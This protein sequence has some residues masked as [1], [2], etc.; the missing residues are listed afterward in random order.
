MVATGILTLPTVRSVFELTTFVYM[1]NQGAPTQSHNILFRARL[2][3]LNFN[4]SLGYLG[5]SGMLKPTEYDD[6]T[7]Y[8]ANV[9]LQP[10]LM[11][12]LMCMQV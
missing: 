7:R 3:R 9:R 4:I 12:L 2:A 1:I 6:F 10:R 5:Q 8:N 11:T